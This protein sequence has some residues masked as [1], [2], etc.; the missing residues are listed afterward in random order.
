MRAPRVLLSRSVRR[1]CPPQV[2]TIAQLAVAGWQIDEELALGVL[3]G[4]PGIF[5][6][7]AAI[8]VPFGGGGAGPFLPVIASRPSGIMAVGML[9]SIV[10]QS[11]GEP[12]SST[13]M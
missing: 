7:N 13:I 3:G 11:G 4:W 6:L 5:Y 9:Y 12:T 8:G 10:K 2:G 1:A